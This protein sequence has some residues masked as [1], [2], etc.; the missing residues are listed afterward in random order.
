M[1]SSFSKRSLLRGLSAFGLLAWGGIGDAHAQVYDSSR[2]FHVIGVTDAPSVFT[3][4]NTGVAVDALFKFDHELG[5]LEITLSNLSGTP[6]PGGG[7]YTDGILVGFGFDG[8]T[9]LSYKSG[10][11]SAEGFTAGEPSGVNFVLGLGFSMSGGL[12]AAG[13]GSFDFGAGVGGADGNGAGGSPAAGIAGGYS[14]TFRFQFEGDLTAFNASSFFAQN[15]G[16]ADL[17]FRLKAVGADGSYSEKIAFVVADEIPPVPEP[18]SYG[19][20]GA[21]MLLCAVS[22]KW[23]RST[24]TVNPISGFPLV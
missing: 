17:G 11:F 23:R 21:A 20:I 24:Q 15:G 3:T 10:S 7:S 9:G 18:T 16:D 12:G 4:E 19:V 5:Y 13:N 2:L 6:K 8:P 22:L 1:L 14:A